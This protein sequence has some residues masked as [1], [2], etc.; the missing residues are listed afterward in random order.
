VKYLSILASAVLG[1]A[2]I[3]SSGSAITNGTPDGTTHPYVGI[4]V[5]GDTFCSGTL[6][7]PTVFLTAGHCTDAF[8]AGGSPTYVSVDTN[9]G[10]SSIYII[11]TPRTQP[12]FF[13]IPSKG[14]GVPASVG[15]DLGVIVLSEPI[16]LSSYGQLPQL[17][18]LDK[19]SEQTLTAV[20]YGAQSWL[21]QPHGRVPLFTFA[22]TQASVGVINDANAIGTEFVRISTN[23]GQGKGG[24]GPG[25]SGAPAFIT[26]G[27]TIAAI[28]SHGPSPTGS[29]TA[30]FTRLDTGAAQSF[31]Q[32]FLNPG[33]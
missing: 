11:G 18:V 2:V 27:T 23:P 17:G 21:P 20:G 28:G 10:P 30:Y 24:I 7:S 25:D 1:A 26:G 12:G 32:P 8:A 3:I 16:L 33:G 14:V 29:G 15:N 19:A 9:A 31:I 22:R 4:A 13:N 5:A 6:L